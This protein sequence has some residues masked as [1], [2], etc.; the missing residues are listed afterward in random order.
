[1]AYEDVDFPLYQ[2]IVNR[3]HQPQ[4]KYYSE[5]ELLLIMYKILN[6]AK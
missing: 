3:K 4:K 2:E 6:G 5:P 1:M